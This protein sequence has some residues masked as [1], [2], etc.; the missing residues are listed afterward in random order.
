[1][2]EKKRRLAAQG[3]QNFRAS[4]ANDPLR[5]QRATAENECGRLERTIETTP[6]D[7][8]SLS[9]LCSLRHSLSL[10]DR[11]RD[12]TTSTHNLN[13]SLDAIT[14][15]L[16]LQPEIDAYWIQFAECI[17]L[18]SLQRPLAP[19]AR[20][21]L[22]QA[23]AHPAIQPQA[24]VTPIVGL[25]KSHPL[26]SAK[27][28]LQ[29]L[30][31][32]QDEPGDQPGLMARIE[33]ILAEPLL[34]RLMELCVVADPM[35]ENLVVPLRR[36]VLMTAVSSLATPS[37]IRLHVLVAVAHQCFAT[38]YVYDVS[39][40]ENSA[41]ASLETAIQK[42]LEHNVAIPLHWIALLACYRALHLLPEA[43]LLAAEGAGAR[44]R[45]P[46]GP[47]IASLL[48][49]QIMEPAEERRLRATIPMTATPGDAV[50][51]AVG[52]L[53]ESNPYPRWI[54]T[55]RLPSSGG[56]YQQLRQIIPHAQPL[57]AAGNGKPSILIAG[58]GT[59]QHSIETAQRY[60]DARVLAIDLSMASLAYAKRKSQEL[61]LDNLKYRQCDILDLP[62]MEERFDLIESIG[63]LHHLQDPLNGW[64]VLRGLL[65]PNGIMR[66]GLYSDIARQQL[67]PFI[68]MVAAENITPDLAG[69]RRCRARVRARFNDS[70]DLSLKYSPDFYSTS[71]CRD[72]LFHVMEHRYTLPEIGAMI[73]QLDLRFLGLHLPA[74]GLRE[75]YLARYPDDPQMID[76]D[77]WHQFELAHPW[78]F[79]GMY[80]VWVQ[81]NN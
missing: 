72:M 39:D 13:R 60:R 65:K 55:V 10:L 46:A 28:S 75:R 3:A 32:H 53:Y 80:K 26:L 54:K 6:G 5:E 1:L 17:A 23:L 21:L 70:E 18:A 36:L 69:I 29:A 35:I 77:H 15:A 45:V 4:P 76:L 25:V 67:L 43:T 24:L 42:A 64:R 14:R 58:C 16:W 11:E 57:L 44:L 38:E 47:D 34:L 63:V 33:E 9:R 59:G 41:L 50:S 79:R 73:G 62:L 8:A 66:I 56:L 51:A 78:L 52:S 37:P 40:E 68:D 71:G 49:S 22:E 74:P 81:A 27:N 12:H 30:I 61:G 48:R 19:A 31:G 7:H 20:D 2:G